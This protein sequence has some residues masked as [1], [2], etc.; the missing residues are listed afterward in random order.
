MPSPQPV[1]TL[2]RADARRLA[3]SRQHLAGPRLAATPERHVLDRL[4]EGIPLPTKAF[5][6]A[7]GGR[8]RH[9]AHR[10][11]ARRGPPARH[12]AVLPA[13]EVRRPAAGAPHPDGPEPGEWQGRTALLSP[14]G[15]LISD[16]LLTEGLWGFA[17]R[18]EMYVPKAKREYGYYLLPVLHGERR[19]AGRQD[20]P[21]VRTQA[22]NPG[23]RGHPS[24]R[25]QAHG[26]TAPVLT[27]TG[28]RPLNTSMHRDGQSG[29]LL[30]IG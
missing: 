7:G 20:L 19:T 9:R 24:V 8:S 1:P 5:A 13:R 18:N 25:R 27:P 10:A 11:R 29:A 22:R 30:S 14:F 6:T 12:R 21:V 15:D 23:D 26:G 16:R 2:R 3:L 28:G 17:F 4:G